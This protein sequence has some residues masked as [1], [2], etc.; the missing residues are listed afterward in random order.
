MAEA[1]YDDRD[2]VDFY[3][4]NLRLA[5]RTV[6][7][8]L[9]CNVSARTFP[10]G[11]G[12]S[13]GVKTAGPISGARIRCQ[14]T[15]P[16]GTVERNFA[17]KLSSKDQ[18]FAWQTKG[19]AAGGHYAKVELVTADGKPVDRQKKYFR[20]LQAGRRCYLKLIT[21]YTQ[22]ADQVR[23]GHAGGSQRFRL[24]RRGHS[25]GGGRLL[26]RSRPGLRDHRAATE[27]GAPAALAIDPWPWVALNRFIGAQARFS[28]S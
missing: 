9:A 22:P 13:V 18:Q 28:R 24:C 11:E 26:I 21:F 10:R 7:A 2:R 8:M 5:K 16:Q 15:N 12:V 6:P 23:S 4:D 20:S 1:W 27:R 25:A 3:F 14:I 19:L 17:D